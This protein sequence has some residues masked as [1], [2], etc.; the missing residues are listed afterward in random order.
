MCRCILWALTTMPTTNKSRGVDRRPT[1]GNQKPSSTTDGETYEHYVIETPV[2]LD[3]NA[4]E[5][6]S[7]CK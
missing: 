7:C 6:Q 3:G 5:I 4:R 1:R 2:T